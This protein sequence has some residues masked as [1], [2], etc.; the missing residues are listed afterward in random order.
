MPR[1]AIWPATAQMSQ[2]TPSGGFS[3][4]SY[5][6]LLPN[7]TDGWWIYKYYHPSV[8]MEERAWN[9]RQGLLREQILQ[10]GVD[11]V[12]LQETHGE[13]FEQDFGFMAEAGYKHALHRKFRF[14]TATFWRQDRIEL[15]AER[16]KDRTLVTSLRFK[17]APERVVH[18]LNCHL[19]GG[20]A[21]E[22]RFRQAFEGLDQIRKE[23][24]K[25]K[26]DPQQAAVIVCGDFNSYPGD[27]ALERLMSH[28]VVEPEYRDPSHPERPITSKRRGHVFGPMQDIYLEAH[29]NDPAKRP[30][31]L[32]VPALA[33][34]FFNEDTGKLTKDFALGLRAMFA[35]FAGDKGYMDNADVEAWLT[36]INGQPDRG[37][38][39]RKAMA[40]IEER[41]DGTMTF[42]DFLFVYV[43][44]L[45]EGKLWSV[46]HDMQ[47]CGHGLEPDPSGPYE[48]CL[49]RIYCSDRLQ[50]VAVRETL[51]QAQRDLI[52]KD[53][54]TLP[55]TWHPSD[56]L[57][58]AAAFQWRA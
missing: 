23:A 51:T 44:E 22:R 38:E 57:P 13:S 18:V 9:S 29:D 17:D 53:G 19:T 48:A 20:P 40:V 12:C 55:N 14:R 34:R 39:R 6:V 46:H 25:L 5:N 43:S 11:I 42:E 8:P 58:L 3:L 47:V 15:V 26:E 21:P 32:V 36:A 7:S 41:G 54:Q 52:Y 10:S 24:N 33:Q 50:A 31:T 37:S 16:H 30:A 2:Q 1:P 56:H 28:T 35:D 49:D 4:L 27:T 45:R